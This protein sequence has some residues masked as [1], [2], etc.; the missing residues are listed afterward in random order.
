MNAQIEMT[1]YHSLGSIKT[2]EPIEAAA[3]AVDPFKP[4]THLPSIPEKHNLGL[5]PQHTMSN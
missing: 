1:N 2:A 5:I 3:T 4:D